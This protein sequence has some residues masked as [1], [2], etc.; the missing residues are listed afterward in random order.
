MI[1][2]TFVGID[3]WGLPNYTTP[4]G[5]LVVDLEP[6]REQPSIYRKTGNDTDGEPDV[7]MKQGVEVTFIPE[8]IRS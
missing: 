3:F 4:K 6:Q 8:R 1:A 2:L 5:T 7:P